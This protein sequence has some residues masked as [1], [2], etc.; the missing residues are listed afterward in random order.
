MSCRRNCRCHGGNGHGRAA[1]LRAGG[2]PRQPPARSPHARGA[3]YPGDRGG[4]RAPGQP[5][6][7]AGGQGRPGGCAGEPPPRA[8]GARSGGHPDGHPGGGRPPL[9]NQPG[10]GVSGADGLR[11]RELR[12]R[13]ARPQGRRAC[14]HAERTQYPALLSGHGHLRDVLEEQAVLQ[15]ERQGL[16]GLPRDGRPG[17]RVRSLHADGAGVLAGLPGRA[18]GCRRELPRG[19]RHM[20]VPRAPPDFLRG[21]LGE[22]PGLR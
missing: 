11:R 3:G 4:R 17:D 8:Q 2:L 10:G 16:P 5:R 13:G 15:D 20:R 14:P 21:G 19:L 9:R 7:H 12:D 22:D 6:G 18:R 1:V